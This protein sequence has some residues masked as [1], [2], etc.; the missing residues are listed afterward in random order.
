MVIK[1]EEIFEQTGYL[2]EVVLGYGRLGKGD[3]AK[4]IINN[5]AQ[6]KVWYFD[7]NNSQVPA[8]VPVV[9]G[10]NIL[11]LNNPILAG[12]RIRLGKPNY[13]HSRMY[14]LGFDTGE[15]LQAVG[16][17]TPQEQITAK[18][19]YPSVGDITNLRV[20]AQTIPDLTIFMSPTPYYDADGNYQIWGGSSCDDSSI[21]DLITALGSGQHQMVLVCL[22]TTSSD[23]AF[24]T[25][26]AVTGGQ[27]NK[28]NFD[29]TTIVTD[30]T[31][32]VRY[33][34]AGAVHIYEGQT[35][36]T[37][38]DIYRS[39]D[40]RVIFGKQGG[41]GSL[42]VTDGTTTVSSVT[43][44]DF[45]GT[46]FAVTDLGSGVAQ[47]N[48]VGGAATLAK[49]VLDY[50][51]ASD[52]FN[53]TAV[54][55]DTWTDFIANKSFTVDSGYTFITVAVRGSAILG[56]IPASCGVRVVIDSGGTPINRVIGGNYVP[57]NFIN[58]FGG[59]NTI[60][61]SGL[62]AGSHTIKVQFFCDTTGA[63]HIY[64]RPSSKPDIESF[65]ILIMEYP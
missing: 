3:A 6:R 19:L 36:I 45:D 37:E 22:D 28:D 1:A 39:A 57:G 65:G 64:C 4:T 43:E 20:M 13:D 27:T 2:G 55:Q 31:I 35:E 40:P 9:E 56:T 49:S 50:T 34:P 60:K 46:E 62:S 33:I 12:T 38:D 59:V 7:E 10:I 52:L 17:L 53:N 47:I 24:I 15:G 32:D 41:T 58:I 48:A 21:G 14:M 26:T 44:F 25:N 61:V 54:T 51:E 11:S 63:N 23:F 16:G 18:T 42:T 8:T 5:L 29:W 30:M